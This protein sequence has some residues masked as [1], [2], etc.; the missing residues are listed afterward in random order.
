MNDT[1][2]LRYKCAL[3]EYEKIRCIEADRHWQAMLLLV[4]ASDALWVKAQPNLEIRQGCAWLE[5]MQKQS[6]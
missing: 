1:H 4:T 2:K 3:R 5:Q 6:I